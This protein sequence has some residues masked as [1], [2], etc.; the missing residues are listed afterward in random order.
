MRVL[1]IIINENAMSEFT[2]QH[3]KK[4]EYWKNN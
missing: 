1:Y 4:I 2:N 3:I